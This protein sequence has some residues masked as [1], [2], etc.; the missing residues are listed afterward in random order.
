[1]NAPRTDRVDPIAAE[2]ERLGRRLD[3]LRSE[4][5]SR[6]T[7]P[8]TA[9]EARTAPTPPPMSSTAS[10]AIIKGILDDGFGAASAAGT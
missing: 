2:L 10:A 9:V 3:E 5:T 4:L 1:M 7:G 8:D 6:A